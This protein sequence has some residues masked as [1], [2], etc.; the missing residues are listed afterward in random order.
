[1]GNGNLNHD[2]GRVRVHSV[3]GCRVRRLLEAKLVQLVSIVE[4]SVLHDRHSL[5]LSEL[6]GLDDLGQY[7]R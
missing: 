1:M 3:S 2:V 7:L 5:G 4:Q 6:S